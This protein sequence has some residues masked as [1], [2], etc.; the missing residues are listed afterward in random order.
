MRSIQVQD[1]F[2]LSSVKPLEELLEYRGFCLEATKKA[3]QHSQHLSCR[4]HPP[5]TEVT[6]ERYGEVD[7]LL[8]GRCPKSGS[9]FLRELPDPKIWAELLAEVSQYRHSPQSFHAG[10]AQS[11]M[12]HVYE[13]KLEWIRE[14]L[15]FQGIHW[16]R[17]LEVV[18]PPSH[19]TRP[20]QESHCC[21]EVITVN[22]MDLIVDRGAVRQY[23]PLQAAVLLESLDRVHDPLTLIKSVTECLEPGGVIFI[24]ALVSSG[25]D[26][27]VLGLQNQYLY[28]PDR[29]NCFSLQGLVSLLEETG[30]IPLEV[31]TPGVLDV[32]IVLAH[33]HNNPTIPLSPFERELLLHGDEERR[34][35]FQEW[36]QRC[37]LSSFA[38]LV[39]KKP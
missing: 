24:T 1:T 8:Y 33:L 17:M 27:S 22:E 29:A 5:L 36:L 18:T 31:S 10:L 3:L 28:P 23:T 6:L 25:F 32:Q 19:F 2:S 39:A 13:P 4:T 16:P 21:S 37:Q 12:D 26:M 11:R 20:L 34:T 9:L 30:L 7:G 35:A 38:R 14:T 15:R